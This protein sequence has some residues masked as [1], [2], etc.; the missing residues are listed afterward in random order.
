MTPRS[1]SAHDIVVIGAGAAGLAAAR[2]LSQQGR[3]VVILEA[4]GRIGGRIHTIHDPQWPVPVELGA[5][6]IHGEAEDT[7]GIARAAGLAVNLLPDT[8]L[9]SRHGT[10][11]NV[12]DFW[13]AIEKIGRD[14]SRKLARAKARDFSLG[15]YLARAS[16]DSDTRQ[17]LVDFVEGYHAAHLDR[18]SAKVMAQGDEEANEDGGSDK[19]FRIANGYDAVIRWLRTG[20]DPERCFVRLNTV[21]TDVSWKKGEVTVRCRSGTGADVDPVR[22]KSLIVAV[23]HAVLR[24]GAIRFVPDIPTMQRSL[25]RLEAGQVFKIALRFR[26]AFWFEDGFVAKRLQKGPEQPAELNFVH[27]HAAAVPTWWTMLPARVAMITGWSG[28]PR[29]ETLLAKNELAQVDIALQSLSEAV[30]VPRRLVDEQLESWMRHDWQADPFSRAAYTYPAVGGTS[31][32]QALARPVEGTIAFAGEYTDAEQT[33]TVA[34]AIASGRRA[35]K[36]IL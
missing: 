27:A 34:G 11:A 32:Q 28:G 36:A 22:A 35:A 23:P 17:M 6:F 9:M 8:H 26:E 14:I 30:G 31:A 3:S 2:D 24:A 4:R 19:Q 29:A 20:L 1:R 7:L 12:A 16:L 13:R 10:F 18:I 5:E 25:D 15:D 33:G 21:A